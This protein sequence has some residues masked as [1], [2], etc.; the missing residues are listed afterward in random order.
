MV[1]ALLWFAKMLLKILKPF[2][3]IAIIEALI[4]ALE[5]MGEEPADDPVENPTDPAN[6]II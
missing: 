3:K 1:D 2:A 6:P 4:G 5:N